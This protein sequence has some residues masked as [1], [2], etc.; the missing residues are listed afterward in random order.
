MHF[1]ALSLQCNQNNGKWSGL[2]NLQKTIFKKICE[3]DMIPYM[4][5][6]PKSIF[7]YYSVE[8]NLM[9]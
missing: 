3:P 2:L 7:L 9:F 1:H 6:N 8:M 4:F 5:Y